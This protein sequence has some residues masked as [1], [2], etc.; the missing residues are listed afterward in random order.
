MSDNIILSKYFGNLSKKLKNDTLDENLK[1]GC[2]KFYVYI[3]L[4][5]EYNYD[6]IIHFIFLGY[7][8]HYFKN[9]NI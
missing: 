1:K 2:I 6:E 4:L 7:I 9:K 5:K 8:I 3:H